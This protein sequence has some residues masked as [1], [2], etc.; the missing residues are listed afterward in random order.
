LRNFA[1][2]EHPFPRKI[3]LLAPALVLLSSFADCA[4]GQEPTPPPTPLPSP[5]PI[6]VKVSEVN[7]GVTV[8]D[9]AGQSVTGLHPDDFRVFDNDVPQPVLAFLPDDDPGLV[10]LLL[11]TGPSAFLNQGT[12]LH[13]ASKFLDSL[14]AN[15]RIA[16]ALY[17][18]AP[19]LLLDFTPDKATVRQA[20]RS[21]NFMSGFLEL[22][23]VASVCATID[24]LAS[25]PGKK[26]IVLLSS[27]IDTSRNLNWPAVRQKIQASDVRILAVSVSEEIRKPPKHLVLSRE[28][29]ESL[30]F[31]K[32]NLADADRGLRQLAEPTGGRVYFPKSD[33][34]FDHAFSEIA[35]SISHE[36]RLSIAPSAPEDQLHALRVTVNRPF[37]RVAFRQ[38]YLIPK[39]PPD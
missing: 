23:L 32:T 34:D 27:G 24:W 16:L 30:K 4:Y 38:G 2:L 39:P 19:S 15:F 3:F 7:I 20:L 10:V 6:Q 12:E 8:I 14:P 25:L 5:T 36:Y 18:R 17:S 28:Q 1:Y 21:V 9:A 31:V 35:T 11:E 33:E 37:S 26:T 29:R 13:A 22:N